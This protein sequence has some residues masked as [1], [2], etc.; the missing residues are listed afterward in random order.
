MPQYHHRISIILGTY[1]PRLFFSDFTS[2]ER[3]FYD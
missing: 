2:S 3:P 1:L